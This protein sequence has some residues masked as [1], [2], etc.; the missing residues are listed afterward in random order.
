MPCICPEAQV[1]DFRRFASE[2]PVCEIA[3]I[4]EEKK[5]EPD[6]DEDVNCCRNDRI[7]PEPLVFSKEMKTAFNIVKTCSESF[8]FRHVRVCK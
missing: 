4:V 1:S 7:P 2:D 6:Q 3:E 5:K 8:N